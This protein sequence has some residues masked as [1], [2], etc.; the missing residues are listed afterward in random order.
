[1][2]L[3]FNSIAIALVLSV[4]GVA[5]QQPPPQKP[6]MPRKSVKPHDTRDPT[7]TLPESYKLEFENDWVRV[8]RAHYD[9]KATLPE[10]MHPGGA[11]VYLYLNESSGVVFD[12][13]DGYEI[14]RP[15]VKPGAIR[16][17]QG[18]LEYHIARNLADTPTDFIRVQLK[19]EFGRYDRPQFRLP[20]GVMEYDNPMVRVARINVPPGTKARVE[21]KMFPV[22]RIAWTPGDTEWKIDP[23]DAYRF[24]E[25]GTSEEFE[26]SGKVPMQLVTIELRTGIAK[27]P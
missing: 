5:Q 1:M 9:A 12:H 25:K 18:P 2:R 16:V 27:K 8:V 24:L 21:A 11:T 4:T 7:V 14:T 17:G 15:A 26:A 10:H 20:P 22:F 19:T 13:A 6:Q 3:V 23:K